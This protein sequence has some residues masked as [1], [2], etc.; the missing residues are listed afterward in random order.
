MLRRIPDFPTAAAA[1][2][3]A[4]VDEEE[5]EEEEEEMATAGL[6]SLSF[7]RFAPSS[8]CGTEKQRGTHF[9]QTWIGIK[10]LENSSSQ[11]TVK[12]QKSYILLL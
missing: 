9:K 4:A 11:D 3:A 5:Q 2:A 7:C 10:P 6:A 12:S 8:D 1:A